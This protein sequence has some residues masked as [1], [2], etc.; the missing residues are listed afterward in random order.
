MDRRRRPLLFALG[1]EWY[2]ESSSSDDDDEEDDDDY[3]DDDEIDLSD[4]DWRDF[5]AQL[6]MGEPKAKKDGDGDE[7]GFEEVAAKG[8]E[9]IFEDDLDG[10]GAVF[11]S[12]SP[13]TVESSSSSSTSGSESSAEP[14]SAST[15]SRMSA[16][17][18]TPLE[19]SQWAYDSGK[20]IEQGAV[21]L[22]GVEQEFG[23]G[24]RQQYFHKAAILVLDHEESTFTKGIILN[25]PS[26]RYLEDDMNEGARWRVWFGGDVQGLDTPIPDIVCLH[27]L[28]N[29]NVTKVS[30]KV[31]KDI[32]WTTFESAKK[33]VKEGHAK[34]SDFWLF[35]G[36]AGWGPGQLMGELDRKSWYMVATDS[37]TLLKELARQS[38]DADPRDAGLDTWELL[39]EMIG[40]GETAEECSGDFDDLMLKEWAR[41]KLTDEDGEG[42]IADKFGLGSIERLIGM[43]MKAKSKDEGNEGEGG[44]GMINT[45][46]TEGTLVRAANVERSPFLLSKQEYHKSIVLCISDD[47][48]LT[49]GVLLNRPAAKALGIEIVDKE[50]GK[51]RKVSV[52][53]LYG[54][55][56][57]VKGQSPLLWLHCNQKLKNA[58]VGSPFG[59]VVGGIYKCS[60]EEATRSIA[61]G[62][63]KPDDF[64]VVSGVSVWTKNDALGGRGGVPTAG[65]KGEVAAGRFE[66]VSPDK[67]KDVWR[68]L[69]RQEVVTKLNL[70]RNLAVAS[71]AWSAGDVALK[72]SSE[73]ETPITEGIGEGYDEDGSNGAY[74][75]DSDTKVA[76]LSDSAL[77]SW[78]ATFLLGAPSL[79][80]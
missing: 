31:M 67:V 27:S 43:V 14:S 40:R 7:E 30:I 42:S 51:R 70:M 63:A 24:L 23:F 72:G 3:D 49:V 16:S 5:R 39:M 2:G 57:A 47:E 64:L 8:E 32:Q 58:E 54:G 60:Q 61:L 22:G 78:V 21:I 71:E 33:L 80:G 12:S 11:A 29:E 38:A 77:Q 18:F 45:P 10:I 55:Q 59:G 9:E 79:G 20:V 1:K 52:P 74:V 26:D 48:H 19:P 76:D 25:R 28:E 66:V 68:A 75:H 44:N 73:N 15:S 53:L 17:S 13:A 56:Y 6:V 50:S 34:P 46:V 69:Q 35:A 41:E 65:L 36:Y 62:T 4:R 37:R